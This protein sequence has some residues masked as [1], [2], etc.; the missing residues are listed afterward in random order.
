M[1]VSP[2][3]KPT[4]PV[5]AIEIVRV[6]VADEEADVRSGNEA[7]AG[8]GDDDAAYYWIFPNMMLNIYQGQLQTNL[9][10][11][12][13]VGRTRVIFE[14]F[15]ATPPEDAATDDKWKQLVAFSDLVQRQDTTIC[16]TVHRNMHS[17]ACQPG[18]YSVR[19]ENG[20]HH[21]HGLLHEYLSR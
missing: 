8:P 21:F 2:I 17:P 19:R 9:V 18:R 11:P 6:E 1:L 5:D 16:E 10:V 14:W 4:R 12:L 13:S 3:A 15:A 7:L 20:L